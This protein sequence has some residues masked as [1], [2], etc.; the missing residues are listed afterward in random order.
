MLI[1]G[2]DAHRISVRVIDKNPRVLQLKSFRLNRV[3]TTK[4]YKQRRLY[5]Y[6]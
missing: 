2:S 1:A 5:N 3:F 4:D 6:N